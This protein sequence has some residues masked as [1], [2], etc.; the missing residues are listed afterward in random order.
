M[1]LTRIVSQLLQRRWI[2]FLQAI[3]YI[4][5][6]NVLVM[7]AVAI[8]Q[9]SVSWHQPELME[10]RRASSVGGAR[11]RFSRCQLASAFDSVRANLRIIHIA[12]VKDLELGASL[13][14]CR[15]C[16]E[17]EV[18]SVHCVRQIDTAIA[19]NVRRLL[20]RCGSSRKQVRNKV[21]DVRDGHKA[22]P[23]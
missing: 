22:V 12:L 8:R 20:D 7:K 13:A 6:Q 16:Q 14:W 15:P 21:Y 5:L 2:C 11:L 3:D 1:K 10:H 18:D 17:Y 9:S 19:V 4:E 23:V